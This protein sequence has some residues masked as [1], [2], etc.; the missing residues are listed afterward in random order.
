MQDLTG[1]IPGGQLTAAEWNQLPEE[2]QKVITNSGQALSGGTLDQLAKAIAGYSASGTYY[3]SSGAANTYALTSIGTLQPPISY[4]NGM[5]IR[6]IPNI[7]NTGASTANVA[8]LGNKA[9]VNEWGSPLQ[10][11]QLNSNKPAEAEFNTGDDNF[12]LLNSSQ[13]VLVTSGDF[14]LAGSVAQ[15]EDIT[16]ITT[17]VVSGGVY[18]IEVMLNI[19]VAN[20]QVATYSLRWDSQSP[21]MYSATTIF[22]NPVTNYTLIGTTDISVPQDIDAGLTNAPRAVFAKYIIIPDGDAILQ[23]QVFN[24]ATGT[25]QVT[26]AGNSIIKT[27]RIA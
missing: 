9:I 3:T 27:T 15:W 20:P 4:T 22:Q 13:V 1:K 17:E 16:G 24:S 6:F 19:E 11:G 5:K 25:D 18:E 26:I 14:V 23:Y 2:V 8:T 7:T 21:T 12:R 10:K